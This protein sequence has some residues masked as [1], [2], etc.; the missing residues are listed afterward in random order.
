MLSDEQIGELTIVKYPAEILRQPA[1][2]IDAL[3]SWVETLACK[4]IDLMHEAR[5]VG[6]AG[7]QVGLPMRIFIY[8]STLEEGD[9]HVLINAEIVDE[10]GWQESDEGCLSLPE[11]YGNVRRRNRVIVEGIDLS[12]KTVELEATEFLA[13]IMQHEIDHLDGTLIFQRMSPMSKLSVRR[14]LKDMEAKNH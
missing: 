8:N 7:N 6:L 2:K 1:K 11:I 13:R 9:D 3:D 14:Q 4:M 10:Q 5:G 12:G